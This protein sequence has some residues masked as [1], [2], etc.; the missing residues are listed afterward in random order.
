MADESR[1]VIRHMECPGGRGRHRSWLSGS[2]GIKFRGKKG[3]E[4]R[5]KVSLFRYEMP[6]LVAYLNNN[7]PL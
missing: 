6:V 5:T 7:Y 3:K 4:S 2:A 1:R